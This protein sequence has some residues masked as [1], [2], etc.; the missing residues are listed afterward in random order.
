LEFLRVQ[1]RDYEIDEQA[2]G[3]QQ[4][5]QVDGRHDCPRKRSHSRNKPQVVTHNASVTSR[6]VISMA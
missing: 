5:G 6:T 2:D 4:T 3:Q 1:E